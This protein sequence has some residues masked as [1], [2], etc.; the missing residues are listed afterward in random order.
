MS[1]YVRG[2]ISDDEYADRYFALYRRIDETPY[3]PPAAKAIDDLFLDIDCLSN[4]PSQFPQDVL[5]AQDVRES[6]M[7]ALETIGTVGL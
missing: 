1:R 3:P 7:R 4:D 2:E 5:S 6:T